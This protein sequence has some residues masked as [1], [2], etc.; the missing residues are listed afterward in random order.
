MNQEQLEQTVARLRAQKSDDAIVEAKKSETKLPNDVWETV[1]SFANTSGGT[2]ILG[3]D[4]K[5]RFAAV[6]IAVERVINQFVE[7]IG[8]GSKEGARLK[9]PPQYELQRMPFEGV[10]LVVIDI[11]ENEIGQKPCYIEARG[12]SAGSYRRVDDKDIPLSTTQ[13]FEMQFALH[14]ST[15]EREIVAEASL[16]DLDKDR[17][18][19]FIAE[20]RRIGSR[21]LKGAGSRE[22]EM[23]RLNITNKKGDIR[24]AALL[25]FG[26]YP[27]QYEPK[28]VIDVAVHP[29]N[30]KS[31]PDGP[32]F[33]DR[34][35]C[36]GSFV[37]M[38]SDAMRAIRRNLRTI[39]TVEG[40]GR[41][42]EL[43]I[44][45]EVLREALANAIVHRE[46]D[47]HFRGQ[48]ISV[49]IFSNRIEIRNPGGL[50]GGVTEE[51]IGDGE[52]KCRNQMLMRFVS[53]M[54]LPDAADKPAEGNGSGVPLMIRE[55]K[56]R[57]LEVPKF[58]NKI[59]GFVIT[60]WRG[61]VELQENQEWIQ[62]HDAGDLKRKEQ[63]IL[64][65]IRE[66]RTASVRDLHNQLGFDSDEIR[67]MLQKLSARRLIEQVE[68]D[69]YR[70]KSEETKE[71]D[72]ST[73]KSILNNLDRINPRSV[74]ELEERTG[75]KRS[76]LRYHMAK[77]VKEGLVKPT[78][79]ATSR[80][81]AYVLK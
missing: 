49:D 28:L 48:A 36:E 5:N 58:K 42:D 67:E 47:Q 44:P 72:L 57:G 20:E 32:R 41:K 9:N 53:R 24:L 69:V 16:T 26:V 70:I 66:T 21:A 30:E 64:I 50:W 18:D 71:T 65:C 62:T 34:E 51:T 80:Q 40:I 61:G 55:M 15:A 17:I 54:R 81:R 8:A 10:T 68:T 11:Y 27:Q 37:D 3:L 39:S 78:A 73:R 23:V 7:G 33:L 77:L 74:R 60:L 25:A 35:V 22:E 45:E 14:P 29:G 38:F 13:V 79:P 76:T 63:T 43:E 6:S 2:I 12:V 46:Y 59:D 75:I 56:E 19:Q 1:S 31:N 52:S 4:E